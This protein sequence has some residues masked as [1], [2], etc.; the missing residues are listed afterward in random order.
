MDDLL[1][2]GGALDHM[3]QA[4]PEAP[5]PLVDLSTGINPW[6]YPVGA[7]PRHLLRDLPTAA[8]RDACGSAMAAAFGADPRA[9]LVVPGSELAI[10]LLPSLL[11]DVRRVAVLAPGYGDHAAAWESAG[12]A[13]TPLSD[14]L[15]PPAECDAIVLSNPNNPDG[16]HWSATELTTLHRRLAGDNRWLIVDEAY[17]EC[18]PQ[19]SVAHL[20]SAPG[21][22]VLR[23]FGKFYG[24]AGLRLGALLGP[25]DVLASAATLL[26][27]WPVSGPALSV[28]AAAYADVAWRDAMRTRL[29]TAAT[30]LDQILAA[31]GCVPMGGSPLFRY[32]AVTDAARVW[33]GLARAGI[34]V[35]RF[36]W[37][38]RHLRIGIPSEDAEMDRLSRALA[39]LSL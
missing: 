39:V 26:G 21:L 38:D 6:S 36:A 10:R 32:V 18:A 13:V 28:G 30:A 12:R 11:P 15:D 24:L 17:A 25:P 20:A 22:I 5:R 34:Y 4:F 23:S 9:L 2:H 35:R 8:L 37:S 33:E 14:P 16:R 27:C 31:G 7:M 3:Q 29:A 19:G 1:L